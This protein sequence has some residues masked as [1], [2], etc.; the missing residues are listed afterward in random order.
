EKTFTVAVLAALPGLTLSAKAAGLGIAVAKGSATAKAAVGAGFISAFLSFPL[1]L[2][3]NYFGYRAGLAE[4]NSAAEREFIKSFYARLAACLLGFFVAFA[5]LALF[6][7][8][9][10]RTSPRLFTLA[11]LGLALAYLLAT[12]GLSIW[13]S[14]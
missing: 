11:M 13:S 7:R 2:A 6:G 8:Q 5:L 12:A 4:A 9:L 14:R 1:A 3:G 10:I